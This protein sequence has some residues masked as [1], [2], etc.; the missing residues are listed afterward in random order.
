MLS[1]FIV[2]SYLRESFKRAA[3]LYRIYGG[4]SDFKG[5]T[6]QKNKLWTSYWKFFTSKE[7]AKKYI[8]NH[9]MSNSRGIFYKPSELSA[10]CKV[11]AID[12]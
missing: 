2:K 10:L 3:K 11:I 7:I 9:T 4:H 5:I 12:R 1:K 6:L 8:S